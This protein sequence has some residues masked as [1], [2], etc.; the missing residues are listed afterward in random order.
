MMTIEK[1][2][3]NLNPVARL[4]VTKAHKLHM[5][6]NETGLFATVNGEREKLF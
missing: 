4:P 5:L 1:R 3:K 6:A 2:K